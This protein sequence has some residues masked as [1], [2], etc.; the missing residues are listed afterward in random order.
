MASTRRKRNLSCALES[1]IE[2]LGQERYCRLQLKIL[3]E[4]R[5][6][7]GTQEGGAACSKE[8]AQGSWS[9][10]SFCDYEQ[11]ISLEN[12]KSWRWHDIQGTC[13]DYVQSR[14]EF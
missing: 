2:I 10:A 5:S 13:K 14:L 3:Y 4:K 1:N 11:Y 9:S 8:G 6:F 12:G 7:V